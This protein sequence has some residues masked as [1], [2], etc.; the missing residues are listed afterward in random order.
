MDDL[1]ELEFD[2][3][4][5]MLV[6]VLVWK[7]GAFCIEHFEGAPADEPEESDCRISVWVET[8]STLEEKRMEA[9]DVI[10]QL[11]LIEAIQGKEDGED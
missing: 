11:N 1:S 10:R 3:D 5:L 2:T 6:T 9:L 8:E 4:G 7:S